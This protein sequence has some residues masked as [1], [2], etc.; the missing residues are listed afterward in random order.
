MQYCENRYAPYK[1]ALFF[2]LLGLQFPSFCCKFTIL[3]TIF[4]TLANRQV[5][6]LK[7]HFFANGLVLN[8]VRNCASLKIANRN[9]QFSSQLRVTKNHDSRLLQSGKRPVHSN[10]V[11]FIGLRVCVPYVSVHWCPINQYYADLFQE[12]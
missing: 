9:L 7:A 10:C 5:C 1:L 12:V 8:F 4:G 6:N 2:S 3:I 11:Q